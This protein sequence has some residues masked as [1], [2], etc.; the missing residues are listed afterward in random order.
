MDV[1]TA[2]SRDYS[3]SDC[4]FERFAAF[5]EQIDITTAP[6]TEDD[7]D[8]ERVVA[9]LQWKARRAKSATAALPQ[10]AEKVIPGSNVAPTTIDFCKALFANTTGPV[11]TC[12]FPNE[13]DDPNQAAERHVI[14]RD[15][16]RVMAFM[17]KWDKPGRGMFVC[18]A[19]LKEGA[20]KRNKENVEHIVCLHADIDFKNVDA[21]GADPKAE[22]LKQLA[23]LRLLPSATV[24]SG[25]GPAR[26]LVPARTVA[27]DRIYRARRG[28]AA[29][30][31]RR[32]RRR[33][34]GVRNQPRHARARLTQYQERR[35][36]AGRD[37]LPLSRPPL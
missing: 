2:S 31:C 1:T 28:C 27:G 7:Y 36:E 6:A 24:L 10:Q 12:S 30:A 18:V 15:G 32:G 25:G 23:R 5:A 17:Q 21:L 8:H 19:V 16:A 29:P 35:L 4:P 26:L 22:V 11:Y 13:R 20:Q 3:D 37:R 33:S 14:S 9:L 34:R